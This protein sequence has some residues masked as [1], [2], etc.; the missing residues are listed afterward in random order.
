MKAK[1]SKN[2]ENIKVKLSVKE[3]EDLYILYNIYKH[4][5]IDNQYHLTLD[6]L[7]KILCKTKPM[8]N[9]DAI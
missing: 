3:A 1:M 8:T 7:V 4:Y 6:N 2:F 5:G 9:N